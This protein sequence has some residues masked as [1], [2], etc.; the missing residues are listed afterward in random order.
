MLFLSG[1]RCFQLT[2]NELKWYNG[3]SVK[4]LYYLKY[5]CIHV[6]KGV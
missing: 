2:H 1:K 3:Y 6:Y 4:L 5:T